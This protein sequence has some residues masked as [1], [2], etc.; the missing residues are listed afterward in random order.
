M[1]VGSLRFR[2]S[3]PDRLPLEWLRAA[4]EGLLGIPVGRVSQKNDDCCGL[5]GKK[6]NSGGMGVGLK[7]VRTPLNGC[8][9]AVGTQPNGWSSFL[10]RSRGV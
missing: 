9:E 6:S 8:L 4:P 5:T 2:L 7:P 10:K 3:C 1:L